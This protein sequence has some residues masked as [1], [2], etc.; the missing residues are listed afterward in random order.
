[1]AITAAVV[2]GACRSKSMKPAGPWVL[3]SEV[4]GTVLKDGAPV[5]GAELWQELVW[6]DVKEE[7]PSAHT[8]SAADGQFRFPAVER[9]PGAARI[10]PHQ[11]VILQRI[12]IRY[13]GVEYTAWRHTKNSYQDRSELDGKALKLVCELSRPPAFEG[14]HYGICQVL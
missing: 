4:Q 14:T 5:A 6:S 11:P 10:V 13:Q 2:L 12:Q 8:V 3:A 7:N 9:D 1:V